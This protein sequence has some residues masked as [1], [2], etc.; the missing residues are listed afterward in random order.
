MH[1]LVALQTYSLQI[2]PRDFSVLSLQI[3]LWHFKP[4]RSTSPDIYSVSRLKV[5]TKD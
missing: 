4:S 2:L 1:E 3:T 5:V